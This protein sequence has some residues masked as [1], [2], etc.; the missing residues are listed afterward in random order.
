MDGDSR[1]SRNQHSTTSDLSSAHLQDVDA[2]RRAISA[3]A[4]E[5]ATRPFGVLREVGVQAALKRLADS[6]L[7]AYATV[8]ALVVDEEEREIRNGLDEALVVNTDRVRLESKILSPGAKRSSV[9]DEESEKGGVGK[10]SHERT[11]LI[12]YKRSGVRLV[13]YRNGPGD[14]VYRTFADSV[15]AAVEIK[16]DPSHTAAQKRG[17]GKDIDRLL[18]QCSVGIQ[19]FFVFLDKS[20]S[21]YGDFERRARLDCINWEPKPGKACS[22][23]EI[24]RGKS[25]NKADYSAWAGIL[26]ERNKPDYQYIEIHNITANTDRPL[27]AYRSQKLL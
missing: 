19:G 15:L 1:E 5:H 10:N 16:A 26:V 17:Y 8:D 13:R 6:K 25:K 2:L 23:D 21:F 11:D 12:V 4:A 22:L 14:I 7:G 3:F 9:A 20:S 18:R 27:Y 24:L